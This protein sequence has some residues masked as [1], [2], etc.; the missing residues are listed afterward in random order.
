M[1]L[2][3]RGRQA[4][5]WESGHNLDGFE[6]DGDDLADEAEDVL[7]IVGAVAGQQSSASCGA[8]KVRAKIP[9]PAGEK[10]GASG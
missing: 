7:G 1:G 10:R 6:A 8:L 4:E 9:R 3:S 5:R 2:V